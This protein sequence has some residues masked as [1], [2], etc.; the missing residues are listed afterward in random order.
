MISVTDPASE[1]LARTRQIL[2]QPFDAQK[3]FV[4][5]FSAFLAALGNGGGCSYHGGGGSSLRKYSANAAPVFQQIVQW[6]S[7]H[8]T[9]IIGI[10]L[11]VF[12]I[13]LVLQWLSARGQFMF[14]DCVT[15]NTAAVQKP[16]HQFQELGNN[17]FIFR[18]FFG[19]AIVALLLS[20]AGL[21]W[22]IAR[23]DILARQFG[24]SA[25]FAIV[26]C[27]LLLVGVMIGCGLLNLVLDDFV[28]PIMYR[29][30]VDT[31]TALQVFAREIL[32]GNIAIVIL[33]YLFRF[34]LG[35]CAGVIMLLG[36][37]CTCCI[38]ALPYL[39]S[40]AF[41]PVFVFFRCYS[42]C[43]LAQFGP[44]WQ[45]PPES[46]SAPARPSSGATVQF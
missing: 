28:V 15:R 33:F 23:P 29:R 4:L 30:N 41:L 2:F 21:G 22:G 24:P 17:L 43:F 40:V 26:L 1:A 36:M 9:L 44:E 5:G 8:L 16:W 7:A 20:I 27:G 12:A 6:A 42:L 18:F 32:H 10:G 31:V 37:C 3:W 46:R 11:A 45:F 35:L 38:A 14:L 34:L 39:S 19:L 25:I 13:G